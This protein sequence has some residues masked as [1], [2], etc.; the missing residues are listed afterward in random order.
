MFQ[1]PIQTRKLKDF[2]DNTISRDILRIQNID[3]LKEVALTQRPELGKYGT[4]R[5]YLEYTN[6]KQIEE[7][8]KWLNRQKE[9]I[10]LVDLTGE[11]T[12]MGKWNW[13]DELRWSMGAFG[14]VSS[15]RNTK[16]KSTL[17]GPRD[18]MS[19]LPLSGFL[20]R[21]LNYHDLEFIF[22]IILHIEYTIVVRHL[23]QHRGL[24]NERFN[25]KLLWMS[26]CVF[27]TCF[28]GLSRQLVPKEHI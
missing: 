3:G 19:Y 17:I 26:L 10:H 11:Y 4:G 13:K 14:V 9:F 5:E 18:Y 16:L 20:D 23:C 15:R 21:R 2:G 28:L 8:S 24:T 7:S 6:N 1:L 27:D 22:R 12:G 25:I